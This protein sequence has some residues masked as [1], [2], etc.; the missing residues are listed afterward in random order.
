MMCDTGQDNL[1]TLFR[2]GRRAVLS[3][4][5]QHEECLRLRRSPPPPPLSIPSQARASP[6]GP[7]FFYS[8]QPRAVQAPHTTEAG[9]AAV[10]LA[11]YSLDIHSFTPWPLQ[12]VGH[13]HVVQKGRVFLPH[14]VL[15]RDHPLL[16]LL[17]GRADVVAVI[18]VC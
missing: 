17:V 9:A 2:V 1:S 7:S 10:E 8:T 18:M 12:G 3:I 4:S 15:L 13:D 11:L 16:G 14:F 6:C 5:I